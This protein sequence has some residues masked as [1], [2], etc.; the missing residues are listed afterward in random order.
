M[1]PSTLIPCHECGA[2]ISRDAGVCVR[3]GSRDPYAF[4]SICK[5]AV[6]PS[7]AENDNGV[8]RVQR[9]GYYEYYHHDCVR[10]LPIPKSFRCNHCGAS[11]DSRIPTTDPLRFCFDFF[12]AVSNGPCPQCGNPKPLQF[13]GC[14]ICKLPLFRGYGYGSC[15]S[16]GV[17]C[18]VHKLC[19]KCDRMKNGGCLEKLTFSIFVFVLFVVAICGTIAR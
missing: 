15:T 14:H 2:I 3:C 12:T 11:L 13:E 8:R 16:N 19:F 7:C 4:C 6:K 18:W 10:R 5:E 9:Y 1:T 17:D